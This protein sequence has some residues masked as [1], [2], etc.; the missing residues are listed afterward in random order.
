MQNCKEQLNLSDE[1]NDG[2]RYKYRINL[3]T[4]QVTQRELSIPVMQTDYPKINDKYLGR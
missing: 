3:K 1:Q 4:G 2:P